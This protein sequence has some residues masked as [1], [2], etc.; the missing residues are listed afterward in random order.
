MPELV[1]V[2]GPAGSGKSQRVAEYLAADPDAVHADVTSVWV[3]LRNVKRDPETGRFPIRQDSDITVKTRLNLR[4]QESIVTEALETPEV[5]R[6]FV[7]SSNPK[8]ADHWKKIADSKKVPFRSE[9]HDPGLE[10]AIERLSEV[11]EDGESYLTRDCRKALYR[12]YGSSAVSRLKGAGG[13]R[14]R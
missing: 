2:L 10:K 3:A 8:A 6:V 1:A 4:V 7:E 14:R 9:I 5:S 13:G 12:W 11:G